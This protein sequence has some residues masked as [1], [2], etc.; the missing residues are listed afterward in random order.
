MNLKNLLQNLLVLFIWS[1][2]ALITGM[3]LDIWEHLIFPKVCKVLLK[4]PNF[5]NWIKSQTKAYLIAQ[6][7][8]CWTDIS[9]FS[10]K[11]FYGPSYIEK[12]EEIDIPRYQRIGHDEWEA[13]AYRKLWYLEREIRECKID[14]FSFIKELFK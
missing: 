10:F 2:L 3:Y 7:N 4:N 9:S 13:A 5:N 14:Y 11:Y 6:K 8:D 12:L 1:V